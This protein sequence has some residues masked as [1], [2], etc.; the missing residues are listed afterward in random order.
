VTASEPDL[1]RAGQWSAALAATLDEV[2][3][4]V[5][6]LARRLAD[7]WTDA[8]GQEWTERM[9]LLRHALVRDSDAAVEFGRAVQ[10][11][12]DDDA[13]PTGGGAAPPSAGP[14][15]GGTE[16]RRAGDRRGVTIPR[17]ADPDG[18]G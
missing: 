11:V 8:R 13:L 1:L 7:D 9:V 14:Q 12:A 5:E 6:A 15:L 17:W 4:Q 2:T 3:G 10:R 16:A 18:A